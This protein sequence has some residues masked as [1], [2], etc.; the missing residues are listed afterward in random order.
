MNI[1]FNNKKSK[2]AQIYT[3]KNVCA[4]DIENIG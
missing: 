4:T 2:M 1:N 3:K